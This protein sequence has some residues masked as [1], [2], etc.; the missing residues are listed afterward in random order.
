V[1]LAFFDLDR[2]LLSE[3]SGS[4]WVRREVRS[5]HLNRWQAFLASGALLRYH[6]G[7][8]SIESVLLAALEGLAGTSALELRKRTETFYAQEVRH[9]VRP[10]ARVAI[11][12][13]RAAGDT[14]VLLTTSSGDLAD[15]IA[16]DLR[17]D[18]VLCNRLEAEGDR[19]TGRPQG[20]LCYGAGKVRYA[21]TLAEGLGGSL[22]DAS[23]YSDSY[24]DLP[25]LEAVG[26]PVVVHPDPRLKREALRRG[27]PIELWGR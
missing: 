9:L 1:A 7:G 18:A 2:T 25:M 19:H 15:L 24:S 20:E 21:Q 12:A 3:N 4:L 13:H 16:A 8:T 17:L 5:G 10:G 26:R 23:F 27:W 14:L 22:R 6:L 11:E